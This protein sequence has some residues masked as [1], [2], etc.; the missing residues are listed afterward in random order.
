MTIYYHVKHPG[1]TPGTVL[2]RGSYGQYLIGQGLSATSDPLQE[3]LRETI[4]AAHYPLKPNRLCSSF[5][6]ETLSDAIFFRDNW[7]PGFGIYQVQFTNTPKCAHRVSYTAWNTSFPNQTLQ[8]HEFWRNPPLYSSNT[9][10]FAEEDLIV[11]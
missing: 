1:L 8:A 5:V 10:L 6:F 2:P 7:R 9:E 3:H 11:I 4:R